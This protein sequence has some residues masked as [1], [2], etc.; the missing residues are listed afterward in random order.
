LSD[1][2]IRA[3]RPP[4]NLEN[5]MNALATNW[6]TTIPGVIALVGVLWNA[7]STKTLNWADLQQA[8]VGLGLI[9]AKDFNVTGGTR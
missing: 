9:A 2:L 7:W 3:G 6:M 5:T 1:A 4:G 8:L